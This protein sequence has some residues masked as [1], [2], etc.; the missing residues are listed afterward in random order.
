MRI[1]L[2]RK[3]ENQSN[4]C[5]RVILDIIFIS[6]YPFQNTL[7]I[8]KSTINAFTHYTPM[9]VRINNLFLFYPYLSRKT[10]YVSYLINFFF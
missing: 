5:M 10:L 1:I 8:H 2:L 9:Y 6:Y 4:S 3:N 7:Y